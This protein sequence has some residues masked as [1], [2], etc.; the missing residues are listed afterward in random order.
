MNRIF[1]YL[2]LLFLLSNCSQND[3]PTTGKNVKILFKETKPI[4]EQINANIKINLTKLVKDNNVYSNKT[5]N[6]GNINFIPT[7]KKKKSYKFSKIKN[8][9]SV[10]TELLFTKRNNLVFFDN[11]GN[12]FKINQKFKNL[13]KVNYYSKKEKKLNPILYFNQI[14]NKLIVVDTLS[15]I[16]LI[17]INTGELIWRK[18]SLA[19]F[20]SNIV[21]TSDKIIIVDFDNVIRCFSI[22]N[23]NELWNF[24]TENTFIKSQKKLSIILKDEIVFSLNSIGDLTALSVKDGSL[25]WQTP[26]QSNEI[27]LN[28]FS[29]KVSEM[30][31]NENNLYFSNNRNEFFS[32]NTNSGIIN[33]KQKINSS[34][35]PT[36]SENYIFTIS[37]E[38]YL[39]VVDKENGNI[40]RV[41]DA[42][43]NLKKREKYN[44]VGFIIAKGKI[45]LSTNKGRIIIINIHNS[46]IEK[47]IK[48][49]NEKISR[50]FIN[51]GNIL[52]IKNNAIIKSN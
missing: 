23:G 43:A 25:V 51:N 6:N 17:N 10:D 36:I 8:F 42:L 50:P 14:D 32:I 7:F 46:E 1:L 26:T 41:T 48:I 52:F 15:N 19:P 11:K 33:W 22:I 3:K 35:K 31:L 39:F 5:N 16:F 29:L 38:G 37:N 28:A 4:Q 2:I 45:Y 20:N 47:I 34:L 9:N 49:N 12:I 21:A 24:K 27:L 30:I 13:W 44:P 40:L 18:D